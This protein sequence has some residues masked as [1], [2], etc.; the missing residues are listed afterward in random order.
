MP[1][2]WMMKILRM[3]KQMIP[4]FQKME[5]LLLYIETESFYS[6]EGADDADEVI[7]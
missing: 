1:N 7:E 2:C 5:N 4:E 3:I 6:N